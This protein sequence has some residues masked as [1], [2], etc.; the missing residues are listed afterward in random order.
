MARCRCGAVVRVARTGRRRRYC[1]DACRWAAYRKRKRKHKLSAC[2]SSASCEWP[3]PPE[4]FAAL[5]ARYGPFTLDPCATPDNAKCAR[6]FT[7]ADDGLAQPWTGRVFMNPPYG[8]GMADWMR[9][10]WESAESGSAEVVVCL[11]RASTDTRWWHDY[12]AHGEVEFLRRRVR[13]GGAK[14]SAPFPSA[15]VVFRG[16]NRA[17]K[18]EP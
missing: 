4:L 12:A 15:V 16:A 2:H 18:T 3:T 8:S 1:S 17:T 7:R 9:K 11:V 14:N 10:A 5:D 6:Y 13:F